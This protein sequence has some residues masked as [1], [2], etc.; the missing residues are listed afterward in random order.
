VSLAVKKTMDQ[1]GV[2]LTIKT[3]LI[4]IGLYVAGSFLYDRIFRKKAEAAKAKKL[5]EAMK[6][7]LPE[8]APAPKTLGSTPQRSDL[9]YE[10]GDW[11]VKEDRSAFVPR[12][13]S[14]DQAKRVRARAK[15][16]G[17]LRPVKGPRR[18]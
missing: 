12:W 18:R 14:T 17:V 9:Y 3:G 6:K 2:P 1:L 10:N 8:P 5:Q 4:A 7:I 16:N 13:S 15:K 11:F